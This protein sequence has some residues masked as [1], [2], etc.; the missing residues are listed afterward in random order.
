V[1]VLHLELG[2][3]EGSGEEEDQGEERTDDKRH[4][5]HRSKARSRRFE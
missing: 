1:G 2:V 4:W 3:G 5:P